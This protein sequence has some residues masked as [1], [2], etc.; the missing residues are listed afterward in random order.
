MAAQQVALTTRIVT[1][2]IPYLF[3]TITGLVMKNWK[4]TV[5][6]IVGAIAY[7]VNAVFG[8]A[9]P[10]DAIV[11]TTVFLIGLFAKDSNVTGGTTQ[12]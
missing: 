6:A 1:G 12:Q 4:T 11:A 9:I 8:L 7:V 3:N 5:T 10:S 2:L